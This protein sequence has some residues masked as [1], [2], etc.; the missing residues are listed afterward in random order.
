MY[1]VL[2]LFFPALDAP[3]ILT[4]AEV[5]KVRKLILLYRLVHFYLR[6]R[7]MSPPTVEVNRSTEGRPEN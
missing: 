5:F 2:V 4:D 7:Y 1:L 6:F 3:V